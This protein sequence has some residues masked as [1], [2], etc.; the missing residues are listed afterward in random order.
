MRHRT[1]VLLCWIAGL[2]ATMAIGCG[3]GFGGGRGEYYQPQPSESFLL[4]QVPPDRTSAEAGGSLSLHA[5]GSFDLGIGVSNLPLE[6]ITACH[7][8]VGALLQ[9]GPVILDLL[10]VS[11]FVEKPTGLNLAL[12]NHPF[13]APYLDDLRA[14][15][16]YVLIHTRTYPDGAI[17]MNVG[18]YP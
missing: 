15:R 2:A 11:S 10:A 5:S 7:M 1:R 8:H 12:T 14:G 16:V 6:E 9:D 18:R 4:V 17:R 3:T 13:P